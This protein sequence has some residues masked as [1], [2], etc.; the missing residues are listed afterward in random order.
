MKNVLVI[1]LDW[2]IGGIETYLFNLVK[3]IDRNKYHF[4]FLIDYKRKP[5]FYKELKALECEFCMVT[6]RRDNFL[7]NYS[8]TKRIIVSKKIDLIYANLNSLSNINHCMIGVK[9]NI[10]VII[11]SHNAGLVRSRKTRILHRINCYRLQKINITSLAVSDKAGKWMFGEKTSYTV[12]NNGIDC[13]K[14]K[15]SLSNRITIRKQFGI[16]NE[17]VILHVGAFRKQKNHKFLVETFYE[18][19]KMDENAKLLLIGQGELAEQIRRQVFNLGIGNKVIFMGVRDDIPVILSA[20]DVF[21][22]PS[23]HEGFPISLIEAEANGL[24]SIISDS[25]T[26]EVVLPELCVQVSLSK[27]PKDWAQVIKDWNKLQ[28]MDRSE[29]SQ[30]VEECGLGVHN[31]V[32]KVESIFDNTF[33]GR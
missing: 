13:E 6:S 1:G 32:E 31:E 2:F 27:T 24:K 33:R 22:F 30:L 16:S 4:I 9:H 3:N 25:I 15:Y 5:C 8:E 12:I 21:L 10:P 23:L 28:G 29:C 14:Y 20:G 19:S 26:N 17:C 7:R 11:H 18:Y